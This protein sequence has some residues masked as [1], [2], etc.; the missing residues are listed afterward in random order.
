MA[1]RDC[2]VLA[3]YNTEA[4]P[5]DKSVTLGMSP[6]GAFHYPH[7]DL[8][9][10]GGG[11]LE[12]ACGASSGY[13]RGLMS[14]FY[15]KMPWKCG[16]GHDE[17]PSHYGLPPEWFWRSDRHRDP[18]MSH[19]CQEHLN[20]EEWG[21]AWG[22]SPQLSSHYGTGCFA[23]KMKGE[24]RLPATTGQSCRGAE[25]ERNYKVCI[26][27]DDFVS[28]TIGHNLFIYDSQE[29][30]TS[31][32][33]PYISC[34]QLT[35]P[36]GPRT[37][38]DVWLPIELRYAGTPLNR[39]TDL[40]VWIL[41]LLHCH[42]PSYRGPL[43]FC[44]PCRGRIDKSCCQA[45]GPC[46]LRVRGQC[47]P[48]MNEP[49]ETN[50]EIHEES[51]EASLENYPSKSIYPSHSPNA[52]PNNVEDAIHKQE[53]KPVVYPSCT[54]GGAPTCA[55]AVV[56]KGFYDGH[57]FVQE[58]EEHIPMCCLS[59]NKRKG[60]GR[61][62]LRPVAW[63]VE[64]VTYE[65]NVSPWIGIEATTG[66]VWF[67]RYGKP[68]CKDAVLRIAYSHEGLPAGKYVAKIWIN[69]RDKET[70]E[71]DKEA[72]ESIDV[73]LEVVEQPDV[74][75]KKF[76]INKRHHTAKVTAVIDG[77]N[78]DFQIPTDDFAFYADGES[79]Q[80]GV[81][82][83][84]HYDIG[85]KAELP[86][87]DPFQCQKNEF[88]LEGWATVKRERKSC[89]TI[90]IQAS[91]TFCY[92][93][94]C[95]LYSTDTSYSAGE[96]LV[97]QK[98]SADFLLLCTQEPVLCKDCFAI[99]GPHEPKILEFS[100]V[101][102][103]SAAYLL[104]IEWE[105]NY[106]GAVDVS[107]SYSHRYEGGCSLALVH[108]YEC[109]DRVQYTK[110]QDVDPI[111]IK[112]TRDAV[113][114][115][116]S[117]KVLHDCNGQTCETSSEPYTD[118]RS[119]HEYDV[120]KQSHHHHGHPHTHVDRLNHGHGKP[121]GAVAAHLH[122][123]GEGRGHYSDSHVPFRGDAEWPTS[124][125]G[126]AHFQHHGYP[127]A[128]EHEPVWNHEEYEREGY[129]GF[130]GSQDYP[131]NNYDGGGYED[132]NRDAGAEYGYFG[133]L[134]GRHYIPVDRYTKPLPHDH[135]VYHGL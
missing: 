115:A 13:S 34:R 54:I 22:G 15:P 21:E 63:N 42:P 77:S 106:Y 97:T 74:K 48:Y 81:V 70:G 46:D 6:L 80:Q 131:Q 27:H 57:A 92:P 100:K 56:G 7:P 65:P 109:E 95:R 18:Q 133:S 52:V 132:W 111:T 89:G 120:G 11:C 47:S 125:E 103:N 17:D 91:K 124:H 55:A 117:Y 25:Y 134:H 20:V 68:N 107:L 119:E 105:K 99:K 83:K 108:P 5:A 31:G 130:S 32:H 118:H 101:S 41:P 44:E 45:L 2:N 96:G 102:E 110:I 10:C 123:R 33:Y 121:Y 128:Y 23:A 43:R 29:K 30:A 75:F 127:S 36:T 53:T 126:T 85:V 84:D 73:H 39:Y 40:K 71:Y 67:D 12:G 114:Q 87:K 122:E 78:G 9:C 61:R 135:S 79:K 86:I 62:T 94:T 1:V 49:Q 90:P 104:Q 16:V 26:E 19:S 59:Y 58:K 129:S 37:E 60:W 93:P 14:V 98:H 72:D 51:D 116:I 8:P 24:V 76:E 113:V 38:G 35:V 69:A 66:E 64:E 4:L 82:F 28:L 88:N 50:K 3:T 112:R